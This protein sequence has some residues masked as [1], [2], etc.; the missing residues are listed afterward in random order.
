MSAA[1]D[2][3][4]SVLEWARRYVAAGLSVIPVRRG[5]TKAPAFA[6][7]REF[8]TRRATDEELAKWFGGDKHGIGIT[9]G[10][11]SGNL[12]V[13][14]FE[15]KDGMDGYAAWLGR[16]DPRLRAMVAGCPLVRTPT[17]GRHLYVRMSEPAPGG[18][19]A[20]TASGLTLIEVRGNGHFVLAPGS[21]ADCHKT[22]QPYT[23]DARGWLTW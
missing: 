11:A 9:G 18:V 6:G 12:A 4:A 17:G 2:K 10:P 14:D 5:G 1:E 19:L 13:I 23:F 15:T 3:P 16:A 20:R 21:P 22:G 8:S 7:W